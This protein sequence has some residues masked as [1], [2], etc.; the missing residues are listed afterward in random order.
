M[1]STCRR[2]VGRRIGPTVLLTVALALSH[3]PPGAAITGPPDQVG[4]WGPVLDWGVQGK[5]M[6]LL[7]TGKVLVWSAG[8]SARVWDPATGAF[9]LTPAPFG[10]THCA[11]QVTLADGRVLVVGGQNVD[12]HIGIKV[13]SIF[14]PA[15]NTWSRGADIAQARWYPTVTTLPD[16]RALVT[17]GDD[18][19]GTRVATPEIY[20]PGTNTWRNVTAKTLGLYPFMYVLPNGKVYDAGTNTSTAFLDVA[21]SG[22]WSA[23]PTAPF[24]SSSYS[25]SGAMYAPGQILRA[26][27]GDPAVARSQI[28]DT[29]AAAP[30]WEET[31]AMAFSR[32]RMNTPILLD[33]SVMA[34]GGTRASDNEAQAILDGEIWSPATKTWKTVAS[35]SEARMY[36][37]TALTLPDGRVVTA[38]GEAGGRLRAQVYSPPYLFKGSRP[39]ITSSPASAQ[40]GAGFTV[41][42][43]V[44]NIAKV[45]LMR[46]SAV[47]HAIDMNQRYVPL[48]FTQTGSDLAVTA[49]PSANHA[50]PGYTCSS[51]PT[52][53]AC[54]R[55]PSGCSSVARAPRRRLRHL[56]HRRAPR[57][58]TSR[59]RRRAAPRR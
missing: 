36:H 41:S 30:K 13:T 14:D 3:A 51:S 54:R 53:T 15:T 5:H 27:G 31:S 35:M 33:G 23:G 25:E 37:S 28:I 50:P 4:Q 8:N 7:N 59:R 38:G 12:T 26:G 43:N 56:R 45:A 17:S 19:T 49:P 44:T 24:G 55:S 9:T 2:S 58:R 42:T 29:T 39:V 32:R 48:T 6:A 34:V 10:D 11:G 22:T 21:G 18:Q 20:D 46:P 16:G 57:P 47:T 40:Y 1:S 52:R